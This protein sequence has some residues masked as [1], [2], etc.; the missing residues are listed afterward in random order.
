MFTA[1]PVGPDI[2][3]EAA[4]LAGLL[5]AK[6]ARC[7]PGAK[8]AW[9]EPSRMHVTIRFIGDVDD[10][11][12]SAVHEALRAPLSVPSF[13]CRIG[14]CGAFPA[15]REP[16]AIW[17]GIAAGAD[18]LVRLNAE[19]STR[20]SALGIAPEPR[21]FRPHLTLARIRHAARLSADDLTDD[22]VRP[23]IARVS[24]LQLIESRLSPRGPDY[25][26]IGRTRLGDP[27][28]T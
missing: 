16:R 7:A 8:I 27:D 11:T 24:E 14:S 1:V 4:R 26:V 22:S 12:A 23:A 13:D 9:V 28:V 20:L 25:E 17:I 19:V 5:R 18:G 10:A 2:V 21:P 15:R 6:V 3:A